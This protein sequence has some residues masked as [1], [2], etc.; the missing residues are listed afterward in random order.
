MVRNGNTGMIMH[1]LRKDI[2][3]AVFTNAV[4]NEKDERNDNDE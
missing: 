2:L 1:V 3:K 4:Y